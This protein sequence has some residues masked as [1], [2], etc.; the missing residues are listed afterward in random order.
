MS[1]KSEV[2]PVEIPEL[3][4]D[5]SQKNNVRYEKGRFLGKVNPRSKQRTSI[6]KY[7][8]RAWNALVASF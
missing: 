6:S 4:V 8:P 7:L 5:P 2:P 1:T 3:I